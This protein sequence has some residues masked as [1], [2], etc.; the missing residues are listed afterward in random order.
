MRLE[1]YQAETVQIAREYA[2]LLDEACQQIAASSALSRL[3]QKGVLHAVQVL[4]ENTVG[5]AK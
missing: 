2:A 1:L 4:I 3:E 5:K